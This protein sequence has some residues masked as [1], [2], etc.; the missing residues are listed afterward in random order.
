MT[1]LVDGG[2]AVE[3]VSL[4]FSKASDTVSRNTVMDK[5]MKYR[6]RKRTVRQTQ[7][8]LNGRAQ[9]CDRWRTA[10]LEQFISAVLLQS[11]LGPTLF[12]IL[13]ND[14]H[15]GTDC[16]SPHVQMIQN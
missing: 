12:N 15:D 4:D 16:K 10:R 2:R 14:L 11:T 8:W 5:L 9:C 6:L 7:N 1:G 13:I 3:A